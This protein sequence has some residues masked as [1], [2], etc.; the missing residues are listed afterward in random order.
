MSAAYY[1][2]LGITDFSVAIIVSRSYRSQ[3]SLYEEGAE[4]A[5]FV[6]V[7]CV[8]ENGWLFL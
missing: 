2:A 1:G 4:G 6:R 3:Q 7:G 5:G 8:S